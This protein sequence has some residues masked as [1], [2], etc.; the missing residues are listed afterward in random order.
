MGSWQLIG[1]IVINYECD[2]RNVMNYLQRFVEIEQAFISH[3]R[4]AE[5]T[6]L[7]TWK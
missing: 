1:D 2:S 3:G 4:K 7:P 6:R 5:R